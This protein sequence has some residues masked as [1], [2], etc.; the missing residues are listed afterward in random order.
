MQTAVRSV[1][2]FAAASALFFSRGRFRLLA[3][4]LAALIGFIYVHFPCVGL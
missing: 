4:V 2:S 3:L 1:A